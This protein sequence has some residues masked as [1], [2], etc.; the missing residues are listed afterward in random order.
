[1]SSDLEFYL[2]LDLATAAEEIQKL[3][4]D[5]GNHHRVFGE[6]IR[7]LCVRCEEKEHITADYVQSILG[8]PDRILEVDRVEIWQY[9]WLGMHG[10]DVYSSTSPF[11]MVDG[12]CQGIPG[13]P[14]PEWL[15]D[16]T[17]PPGL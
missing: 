7:S 1:M 2:N 14:I 5:R 3:G 13:E 17:L 10:P 15:Q 9:N 16:G 8:K 4:D 12:V 11:V 6:A